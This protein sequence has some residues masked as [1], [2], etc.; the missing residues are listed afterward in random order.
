[1]ITLKEMQKLEEKSEEFGVTKL[2][3]MEH[4]G[5][6][7]FENVDRRVDLQKKTVIVFAGQGNN[8]GD[9]F[10]AARYFARKCFIFVLFFG[11]EEKLK[12]E[13]AA[14][15]SRI[16][17]NPGIE[18]I[19]LKD[20]NKFN[21]DHLKKLPA[22]SLVLV[23]ALLGAGFKG[24]VREPIVTAIGL[25]NEMNGY[26]AVVDI[27][28][29]IGADDGAKINCYIQDYDL[30]ITFHDKKTGIK[31]YPIQVVADIGIPEEAIESAASKKNIAQARQKKVL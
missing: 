17:N 24:A 7:V 12:Y 16:Q 4:A 30:L 1:M 23:D 13:T 18:I 8:A 14:N 15:F 2:M 28:S 22:R 27:P 21:I 5:R 29:G 10:V 6:A 19:R 25:F 3:L 9:G 11:E 26:K 20:I 31:D